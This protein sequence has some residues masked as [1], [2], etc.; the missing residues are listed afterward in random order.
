M[1]KSKN[2]VSEREL[3]RRFMQQGQSDPAT[4]VT[5][6]RGL[7]EARRGHFV[8][9]PPKNAGFMRRSGRGR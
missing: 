3:H 7:I 6:R 9:L 8:S 5:I 1:A 2:A 4:Q